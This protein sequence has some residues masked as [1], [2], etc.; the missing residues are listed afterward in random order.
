MTK[1]IHMYISSIAGGNVRI[2]R[3]RDKLKG[4]LAFYPDPL[5]SAQDETKQVLFQPSAEGSNSLS[6]QYRT[7]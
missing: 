4:V 6:G 5:V 3:D 2:P 7:S 1:Y